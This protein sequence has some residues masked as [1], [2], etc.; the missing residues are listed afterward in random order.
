MIFDVKM[1]FTRKSRFVANG[2]RSTNIEQSK[3]SGVV[4]RDTV[5]IYLTYSYL[6]GIDAMTAD[7]QN[8]YLQILIYMN[9]WMVLIPELGSQLKV[10]RAYILF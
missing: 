10:K 2:Y 7:I 9:H 3:Y 4:P 5:K 1:Y 8:V 6:H